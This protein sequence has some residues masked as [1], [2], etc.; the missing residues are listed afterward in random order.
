VKTT[1]I[2]FKLF[3][4]RQVFY[5][6]CLISKKQ[7]SF[8]L[9]QNHKSQSS[10]RHIWELR[11][12]YTI[13]EFIL[14]F[15]TQHTRVT[16]TYFYLHMCTRKKS[17]ASEHRTWKLTITTRIR[18]CYTNAMC[19]IYLF[20]STFT[21]II[22]VKICDLCKTFLIAYIYLI[23]ICAIEHK[24]HKHVERLTCVQELCSS[25]PGLAKSYTALQKHHRFNIMQ[26]AYVAL[27]LW[28]GDGHSK[29][30]TRF[31]VI[32]WQV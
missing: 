2:F 19:W 32:W 12:L 14:F 9:V 21:T 1:S 11:K 22:F 25:N 27:V 5:I 26:V 13:I 10:T 7:C 16:W 24:L 20:F 30:I 28:C 31:D 15:R 4:S 8:S 17:A 18:H 23:I 3:W 6:K 29:L